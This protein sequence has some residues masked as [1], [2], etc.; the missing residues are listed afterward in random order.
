MGNSINWQA[1]LLVTTLIASDPPISD[2]LPTIVQCCWILIY[3][4]TEWDSS[5]PPLIRIGHSGPVKDPKLFP[6]LFLRHQMSIRSGII[7]ILLRKNLILCVE[8]KA[9]HVFKKSTINRHFLL[10]NSSPLLN[11]PTYMPR[12]S[13]LHISIR[14]CGN[15]AYE[16]VLSWQ[17]I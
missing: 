6:G 12:G 7:R 4:W 14:I 17:I 1:L 2:Q 16:W 13:S 9:S 5:P 8:T 15:G 3:C 11:T 10:P